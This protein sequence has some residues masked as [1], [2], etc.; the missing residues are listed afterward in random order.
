[1]GVLGMA[2]KF[3]SCLCFASVLLLSLTPAYG[4]V[5][6]AD[7]SSNDL[8]MGYQELLREYRS[9]QPVPFFDTAGMGAAEEGA[10]YIE[11]D[12]LVMDETQSKIGRDFYDAFYTRW[13][14]PK[15]AV[16]F[17]VTVR[18]QPVPNRGTR[19][20][21]QVNDEMVFRANLRPRQDQIETAARQAVYYARRGLKEQAPLQIY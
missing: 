17:T 19:V 6:G 14:A 3:Y 15:G 9:L 2:W 8:A 16:N 21:V 12:G 11:I 1:M 7:T 10:V 20:T 4:Q 5:S 18:E 13:E